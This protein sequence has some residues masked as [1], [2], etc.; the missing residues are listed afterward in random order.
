MKKLYKRLLRFK[1]EYPQFIDIA[2]ATLLAFLFFLL[3]IL[4]LSK[5]AATFDERY[6]VLRGIALLQTGDF[7]INVHHPYFGNTLIA[8]P[9]FLDQDVKTFSEDSDEWRRAHKDGITSDFV[10]ANG[11]MI[12]LSGEVLYYPRVVQIFITSIFIAL[13][14]FLIRGQ[15]GFKT[16]AISSTF[17]AISPSILAHGS[18]VTTD[19]QSAITIFLTTLILYRYTKRE[20]HTERRL[21]YLFLLLGFISL[22]TKFTA[23]VCI[24]I[25]TFILF[26]DSARR[27]NS[28]K[29]LIRGIKG[30]RV[31]L[32]ALALWFM[33]IFLAFGG[34]MRTLSQLEYENIEKIEEVKLELE[35]YGYPELIQLYENQKLPIP[36]YIKGFFENVLGK[37]IIRH[38]T[39]MLGKYHNIGPEYYLVAL[40]TKESLFLIVSTVAA[41]FRL[42]YKTVGLI[43]KERNKA[44][45]HPGTFLLFT[46]PIFLLFLSM[47]SSVRLGI[48]HLLPLIPFIALFVGCFYSEATKIFGNKKVFLWV[49]A[50]FLLSFISLIGQ[51]PNY[52]GYFNEIAITPKNG[53]KILHDSNLDWGQNE[54]IALEYLEKNTDKQIIY[55]N[56]TNDKVT[57]GRYH[58]VR[59]VN[60]FG[61]PLYQTE[62]HKQLRAIYDQG[63]IEPIEW[64]A[65]THWL[66][67]IED[68]RDL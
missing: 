13:Y 51:Y 41:S 14:Y 22:M 62:G 7:R 38:E 9:A 4:P 24:P 11:G 50:G 61:D 25:W 36:Y 60:L 40:G 63:G 29:L 55:M 64:I 30:I 26:W 23:V 46:L 21:L 19:I 33:A 67:Y 48:R 49:V 37:N 58:L 20:I 47:V 27:N 56:E 57:P 66:I 54:I 6:H 59:L 17:I 32:L 12:N 53:Y 45:I 31:A 28:P 39:F 68:T 35:L 34:E 3:A 44:R 15:F 43:R 10:A 1:N 42:I 65:N 8:L 2:I 52:I 16:A 5:T 18:I